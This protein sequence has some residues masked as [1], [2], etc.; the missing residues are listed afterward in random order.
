M[1]RI[2]FRDK[3]DLNRN[4][5]KPETDR[6]TYKFYNIHMRTF[7]N[8]NIQIDGQTDKERAKIDLER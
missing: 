3:R 2:Q 7:G 1:L 8:S 4:P 6:E 5:F